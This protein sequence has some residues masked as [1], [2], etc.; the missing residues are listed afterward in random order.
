MVMSQNHSDDYPLSPEERA[1][2]LAAIAEA[3]RGD[4]ISGAELFE[5]LARIDS[6]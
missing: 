4:M 3:D 2:L 5:R 1:E 6:Q